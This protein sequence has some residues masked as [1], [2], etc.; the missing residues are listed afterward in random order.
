MEQGSEFVMQ[1]APALERRRDYIETKLM[2]ELKEQF[3]L[4]QTSFQS[5]YNILLRKSLVNEDP[6]KLDKKISEITIPS[7]DPFTESAKNEQLSIRLSDYDLQLDFINSY[8]E[9]SLN[10]LAM[11]DI[12]KVA[13]LVKYIRWEQVTETSSN[14]ITRTLAAV[15]GRI[16]QGSDDLSTK[17]V[18][19]ALTQLSKVSK[20]ILSLLKETSSYHREQYK[21]E[22]REKVLP[23][24]KLSPAIVQQKQEDALKLVKQKYPKL[25]E[26]TPFYQALIIEVLQ[27]EYSEN[28]DEMKQ[29]LLEQIDVQ[30]DQPKK[31][32]QEVSFSTYILDG[33]RMLAS[34][35]THLEAAIKKLEENNDFLVNRKL[36]FGEKFKRWLTKISKKKPSALIYE[37][38]Y[39]DNDSV[40]AKTEKLNFTKFLED[41]KKRT[42]VLANLVSKM[43]SQYRK[44]EQAP[45][46]KAF[47]FLTSNLTDVQLILRR[48][49]A[50]DAYFKTEVPKEQRNLVRGIKM[51]IN[52]IKNAYV[53]ANQK[54]H[55]YVSKKEEREQLKK[56]GI[57]VD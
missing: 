33:I 45:E 55:E 51:E 36:S 6:Y 19:D 31:K 38:E 50:L 1:L 39:F 52:A 57:E 37:I 23:E 48:L 7:K 24:V 17:I 28:A 30:S 2:A 10:T 25:M 16:K 5:I 42:A 43:S 53:K 15:L 8:Y 46:E 41:A 21:L 26:N 34:S 49:P 27:E 4:M 44:I 35:G 54:R 47:E 18:G 20:K 11:D 14:L 22:F 32:K 29:T 12:K 40:H 56:L 13:E 9:F 3:R